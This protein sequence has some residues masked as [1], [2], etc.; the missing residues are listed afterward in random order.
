ML[1]DTDRSNYQE[2]LRRIEDVYSRRSLS[3]DLSNLQL[4]NIPAR[5]G[6]L[7]WL[8]EL[9]LSGNWMTEIPSMIINLKGLETLS[10]AGNE[11]TALPPEI[12]RLTHLTFLH[13]GNNDLIAL[14][15]E[16]GE[17]TALRKLSLPGNKLT[18]LPVEIGRLTELEEV[19]LHGNQQL[20]ALPLAMRSLVN[21][22]I[23]NIGE[24]PLVARLAEIAPG[25][26][27][28]DAQR[29]LER[30]CN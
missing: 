21:L 6:E 2:A 11:L 13:A 16:I 24:T 4:D 29:V 25:V 28:F 15:K 18:A 14:P 3:L 5:V 10:L 23:L 26:D 1:T 30:L 20:S 9:L 17:L 19:N 22:R 27:R 7:T 12:G 8:K